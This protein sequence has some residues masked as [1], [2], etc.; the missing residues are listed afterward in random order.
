MYIN[1]IYN[2][3]ASN[4]NNISMPY[5][6]YIPFIC[7]VNTYYMQLTENWVDWNSM[8]DETSTNVDYEWYWHTIRATQYLSQLEG[9]CS[10]GCHKLF[11]TLLRFWYFELEFLVTFHSFI[12]KTLPQRVLQ[13]ARMLGPDPCQGHSLSCCGCW[14]CHAIWQRYIQVYVS[15]QL[16]IQIYSYNIH[17]IYMVCTW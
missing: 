4:I 6:M 9:Y 8:L 17:G 10:N 5:T 3:Y 12:A 15:Y 16:Y 13:R 14:I 1:S 11:P 2:I 7:T